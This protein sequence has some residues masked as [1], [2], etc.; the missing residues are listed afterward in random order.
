MHGN[1]VSA[2]RHNIL[3]FPAVLLLSWELLSYAT[4]AY[5]PSS[6]HRWQRTP[7]QM[8]S[9]WLWTLP[10]VIV[11]FWIVRNIPGAPERLLSPN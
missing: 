1:V 3:F 8:R 11:L 7:L 5:A 9:K 4:R 2:F 6:S 10:I